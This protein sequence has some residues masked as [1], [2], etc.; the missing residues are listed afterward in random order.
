[1]PTLTA[2]TPVLRDFDVKGNSCG[3]GVD[4]LSSSRA[5]SAAK[6]LLLRNCLQLPAQLA[7]S[8]VLPEKLAS[9]PAC[10]TDA[11]TTLAI[12]HSDL[13]IAI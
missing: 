13:Y 3:A 4:H 5:G 12:L 9:V 8:H 1:M 7:C 11:C 10:G 2:I 6:T